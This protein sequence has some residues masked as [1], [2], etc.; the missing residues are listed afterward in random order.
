MCLPSPLYPVLWLA[1]SLLSLLGLGG[2]AAGGGPGASPAPVLQRL[3]IVATSHANGDAATA[4]DLVWVFSPEAL[5]ALPRTG[6]QWF[7]QKA[8]L[9][10]GLANDLAVQSLALPPA[11]ALDS[12]PLPARHQR[13]LAVLAFVNFSQA[14][15]QQVGN[16]GAY[17]CARITLSADNV[18][19]N[20]CP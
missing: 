11:T 19:Y 16:L 1:A 14:A 6:P 4:V 8:A 13:A 18:H 2:C 5:A 3:S 10:A 7:D 9:Q 17:P 15:G 12:V 20:A